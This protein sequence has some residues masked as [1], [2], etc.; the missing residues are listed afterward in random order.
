MT[1]VVRLSMRVVFVFHFFRGF[2]T[3]DVMIEALLICLGRYSFVEGGGLGVQIC[4][5][6]CKR[7]SVFRF[8][9]SVLH[10]SF[11]ISF[12][13]VLCHFGHNSLSLSL[14]LSLFVVAIVAGLF[15]LVCRFVLFIACALLQRSCQIGLYYTLIFI[16]SFFL[17][18]T[19]RLIPL[20]SSF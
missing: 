17:S 13:V 5:V 11:R 6:L 2:F 3:S 8:C 10:V 1:S 9:L 14:S 4:T 20:H 18:F 12:S 16:N 19:N 15:H 7:S